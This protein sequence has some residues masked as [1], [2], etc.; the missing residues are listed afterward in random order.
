MFKRKHLGALFL[1]TA[2]FVGIAV[3]LVK[4]QPQ[5]ETSGSV[6]LPNLLDN[7]NAVTQVT[8]MNAAGS[9]KIENSDL[10]WHI[11]RQDSYRADARK[12]HKLLVGL[13]NL[14]RIEP[15]TSKPDLY[16]EI[17]VQDPTQKD[18][19]S[20]AIQLT[21]KSG[22]SLAN[23]VIGDRRPAKA[24]PSGEE[25]YVRL[26]GEAQSWL[27][28][29]VLPQ[30]G[31]EIGDW[32]D[33]KIALI[34]D[35]RLRQTTLIHS[36]GEVITALRDKISDRNFAYR[37]LP[38]GSELEDEWKLNDLG[39]FLANLDNQSVFA[40]ATAPAAEPMLLAEI[41]T[42][43]GLI[44]KMIATQAEDEL[45][46]AELNAQ[47]D[48]QMASTGND[49]K[50]ENLKSADQVRAEVE[51]LNRRWRGWVYELPKFKADYLK[52]RQ[53]DFLKK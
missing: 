36:D 32:L 16:S 17:G 18:S 53:A 45:V 43:D 19:R 52:K 24:D 13:S 38:S 49:F 44:I 27:V 5:D 20:V 23:I 4:H 26:S 42:F 1:T 3:V 40:K 39:K 31:P 6:L 15:K 35:S 50:D 21:N 37:E 22:A 34:N 2:V 9:F 10:G 46:Y 51:Q 29:G 33:K 12:I 41:Q 30:T 14:K 47:Y 28:E 8:V 7:L 48:D 11:P 25:F